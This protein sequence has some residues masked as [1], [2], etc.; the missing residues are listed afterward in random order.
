MSKTLQ[1]LEQLGQN[2]NLQAQTNITDYLATVELENE[3]NTAIIDKDVFFLE[4][5]LNVRSN[6]VC[7]IGVPTEDDEFE[8]KQI[9]FKAFSNG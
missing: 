1:V 9:D 4:Q 3:L 7:A 8:I 2:A 5:S 6:I